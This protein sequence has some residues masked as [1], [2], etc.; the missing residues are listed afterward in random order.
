MRPATL[1]PTA[2]L[3]AVAALAVSS[4]SAATLS[5]ADL[6]GGAFGSAYNS[7]TAVAGGFTTITGTGN[8][9]TSD[10]VVLTG[11][12]TGAQKLTFTFNAPAGYDHSYSAGATI[13]YDTLP[14]DW[15]WDGH[16][17]GSVQ[18]GYGQPSQTFSLD[19]TDAFAGPLYLALNFTHGS[20]LAYSISVPSNSGAIDLPGEPVA[21]V[22][23]PAGLTL[24]GTGLAALGL[25]ARRRPRASA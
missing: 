9:G 11:L 22:P 17:A 21:P 12:P 14:F 1:L 25:A 6:P 4:A 23:V 13:L 3:A 19:L 16:A 24:I 10:N 2:F 20:N 7:L 15:A 8:G 18:V 5:E